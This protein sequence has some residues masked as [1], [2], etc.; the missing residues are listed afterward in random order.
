MTALDMAG[1]SLTLWKLSPQHSTQQLE[2]LD[3]SVTAPAWPVRLGRFVDN[4]VVNFAAVIPPSI[5]S[6]STLTAAGEQLKRAIIAATQSIIDAEGDLTEWDTK[7][8]DGDCGLTLATGAKA[9]Q[10]ALSDFPLNV[11]SMTL[12]DIA[13]TVGSAIGGTSG[14]LYTIF[15][16]AAGAMMQTFDSKNDVVE[17]PLQ[18]WVESFAAGAGAIVKYGGATEGSRT[19]LD[20]MLPA[21]RA[22]RRMDIPRADWIG[23]VKNA[24]LEGANSTKRIAAHEACGRTSYVAEDYVKD[25]PDPGAMA[26]A[27]WIQAI[28]QASL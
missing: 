8:G 24:A 1:F 20:S 4:N 27:I 9:I 10:S 26:V 15:F 25:V 6:T 12:A 28:A 3:A 5:Q 17:V 16:T 21:I 11:P 2:W 23:A 7:V 18:A 22:A 19:M 14:V 13:R